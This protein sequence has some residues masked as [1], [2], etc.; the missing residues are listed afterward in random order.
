MSLTVSPAGKGDSLRMEGTWLMANIPAST[1]H[2]RKLLG[3]FSY[4]WRFGG[5]DN[6]EVGWCLNARIGNDQF[7]LCIW[8][9][10]GVGTRGSLWSV[11]VSDKTH[12]KAVVS[13]L[14]ETSLRPE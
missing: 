6:L 1:S 3:E 4:D 14:S 13:E 11:W 9:H 8:S 2:L 10:K 7:R 5:N 12:L